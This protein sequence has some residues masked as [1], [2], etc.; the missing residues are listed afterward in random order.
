[1]IGYPQ[2]IADVEVAATPSESSYVSEARY[3]LL[4]DQ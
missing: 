3:S 1:M 4:D 2:I